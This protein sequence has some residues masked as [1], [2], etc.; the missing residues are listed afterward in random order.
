MLTLDEFPAGRYGTV[1]RLELAEEASRRVAAFGLVPG[2]RFYVRQ[3]APLGGPLLLDVGATRFLLR[4][5]LARSILAEI[6]A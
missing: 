1:E 5:S 6:E 4:R 2:C 3:I